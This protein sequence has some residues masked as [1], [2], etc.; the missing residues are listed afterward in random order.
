M[1]DDDEHNN[2]GEVDG[3]GKGKGA[4]LDSRIR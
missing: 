2:S 3:M 1:R 4:E